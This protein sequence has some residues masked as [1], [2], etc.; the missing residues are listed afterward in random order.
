[1]AIMLV[2]AANAQGVR[3]MKHAARRF[4]IA[5]FGIAFV[6][7]VIGEETEEVLTNADIVALSETGLPAS[8]VLAKIGATKADFDTSVEQL[9]ALSKSGVDAT[10]IELMINKDKTEARVQS[11]SIAS[12]GGQDS[13][14]FSE[15]RLAGIKD[16]PQAAALQ[17]AASQT[18][19]YESSSEGSEATPTA[20]NSSS[21]GENKKGYVRVY[22]G[23]AY[24]MNDDKD[25]E[26]HRQVSVVS[27]NRLNIG[28]KRQWWGLAEIDLTTL[29]AEKGMNG[30]GAMFDDSTLRLNAALMKRHAWGKLNLVFGAGFTTLRDDNGLLGERTTEERIFIGGRIY[31][32]DL[33]EDEE[34]FIGLSMARDYYWA[35]RYHTPNRWVVDARYQFAKL[36]DSDKAGLSAR[37]YA[38]VP[39]N[40][41]GPSDISIAILAHAEF[42]A[43]FK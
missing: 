27:T 10:V 41:S 42:D 15:A 6:H 8:V 22:A 37:L 12:A 19:T 28:N 35:H 2:W 21:A 23:P 4:G 40:G 20:G 5:L 26:N 7:P 25:W 38:D 24:S 17:N 9:I 18:K 16:G 43:L 32:S 29:S 31:N 14:P 1:M 11:M 13:A 34:A 36:V 33:G 39:M 30:N 3:T